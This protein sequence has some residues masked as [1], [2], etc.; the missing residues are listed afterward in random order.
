MW[1]IGRNEKVLLL[2]ALKNFSAVFKGKTENFGRL[3]VVDSDYCAP[4]TLRERLTE[5]KN[6]LTAE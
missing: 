1:D 4:M 3:S 2:A 6:Q 5:I